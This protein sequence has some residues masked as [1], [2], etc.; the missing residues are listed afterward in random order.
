MASQS[1]YTPTSVTIPVEASI[2]KATLQSM[3]VINQMDL[4]FICKFPQYIQ[5]TNVF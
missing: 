1:V 4:K 5:D 2:D 3:T